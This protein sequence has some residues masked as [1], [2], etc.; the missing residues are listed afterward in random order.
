M[1]STCINMANES[2]SIFYIFHGK[3]YSRN[4][5]QHYGQDMTMAMSNKAW[6]SAFLFS[7]WID[8]LIFTLENHND[9]SPSFPHFLVKDGHSSHNTIDV[10]HEACV[11]GLHLVTS[12]VLTLQPRY[13]TFGCN[14]LQ[15]I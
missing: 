4:Y 6:M 11:G 14:S 10:V 12:S 8:H 5:I 1:V 3:R 2:I 7:T 13:T 9:I 15:V